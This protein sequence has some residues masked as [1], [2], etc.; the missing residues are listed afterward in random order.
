MNSMVTMS[1]NPRRVEP[2]LARWRPGYERYRGPGSGAIAVP[3][4]GGDR[5]AIT[6]PEGG[7]V[8]EV[9]TFDSE[10]RDDLG[11]LGARASVAA[12]GIRRLL[13]AADGSGNALRAS[14]ARRG[15]QID[16]AQAL[17][18][19]AADGHAGDSADFEA[20]RAALCIIAAPGEPMRVDAQN[21]P[22]DLIAEISRARIPEPG[23]SPALPEP[24]ADP[25]LDL[26]VVKQ[27]AQA[28][29][30]RAGEFI[31]I[32]DVAGRQCSDLQAFDRRQLDAGVER[33]LDPTTTR[34][35]MCA[36]YP[37]PGLH[38]KFYN[39][40]MQP[41]VEVVRDTVG[42]H[43]TFGLACTAKYYE[44]QGYFGHPN[45][46]DNFNDVLAPYHIAARRGWPAINLFFNTSYDANNVLNCLESWSRP[47]DY[48]LLRALTDI[49]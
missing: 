27:T 2:G 45:C 23:E 47:G 48:V 20:E 12:D 16:N 29:E 13:G 38:S 30:V 9:I 39:R 11:I 37:G 8:A 6:D 5:L 42:R 14:L 35:L 19:F 24:L 36:A 15:I 1:P 7:Q 44:E 49:V 21:P 22:T 41:L 46:T 4:N 17:Q 25:R 10:G 34:T 28:Y 31:Q 3:L 26:R 18:L 40:D 32:I 33:G 43:D